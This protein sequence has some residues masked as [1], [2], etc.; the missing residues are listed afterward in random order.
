LDI[1]VVKVGGSLAHQPEKLRSLCSRLSEFSG[2]FRL[3]VVPG[4]GEFADTVRQ[5]DKRFSLSNQASHRM[6]ILGMDQYGLLLLDLLPTAVPS[7]RLKDTWKALAE[8]K[9]A[10]FLPAQLM[11]K[12]DP[13]ENSW[14]VTSDSIALYIAHRLR[15]KRLLLA[16]DVDG[17]YAEDPKQN[18]KAALIQELS[19]KQLLGMKRTSVDSALAG[20]LLKWRLDCF[21]LNG[22]YPDRI[23][24]ILE[25][26]KN[27]YTHISC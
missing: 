17:V 23:A 18:P 24:A 1:N 19:V 22:I 4:G 26:Q 20:L 14:A 25:G 9:L 12:D 10:V 8:G 2:K 6:A 3:V 27:V 7:S 21:V 5:L 15:A 11:Q 13:L 16:T